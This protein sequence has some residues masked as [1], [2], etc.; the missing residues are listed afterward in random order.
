MRPD[1][2]AHLVLVLV[3]RTSSST[4][5]NQRSIDHEQCD[6]IGLFLKSIG[7]KFSFRKVEYLASEDKIVGRESWSSGYGRRL[8]V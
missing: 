3:F 7:F 2:I 1:A 8:M 4:Q 5:S 6:Q